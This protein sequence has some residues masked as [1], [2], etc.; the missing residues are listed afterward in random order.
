MTGKAAS[1]PRRPRTPRHAAGENPDKRAAIIQG[2]AQVF[3]QMGFDA[4]SVSDICTAAGVSKS[5]LYV[6]FPSKE[7]LFEALVENRREA[8][9]ENLQSSVQGP[10]PLADRLA[11][12]GRTLATAVCSDDVIAA[13]RIVIAIAERRPDIG[14]RFYESGAAKGHAVLLAMLENEVAQG[15]LTIPDLPLAAYQFVELCTAGL[16]RRRLFAKAET[17]PPPQDIAAT[18]QSAVA[19]FL[20]TYAVTPS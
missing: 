17:P 12:F 19:M 10:A 13:Q 15:T 5:T 4:A 18:A 6:Y 14:T 7:D 3:M 9:F 1:K 2:A 8:M 20:A 16:W 11:A